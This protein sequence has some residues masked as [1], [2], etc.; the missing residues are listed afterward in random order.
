VPGSATLCQGVLNSLS[1]KCRQGGPDIIV[2]VARRFAKSIPE[3]AAKAVLDVSKR[4]AR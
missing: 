4:R 2:W 3:E 1:A